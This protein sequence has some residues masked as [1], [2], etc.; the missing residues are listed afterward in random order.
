[1]NRPIDLPKAVRAMNCWEFSDCGRQPGGKN[2]TRR[3]ICPASTLQEANG[4]LGGKNGGR[5]CAFIIGSF[6]AA[7]IKGTKKDMTKNCLE[8]DFFLLLK[9][10]YGYKMSIASFV[11]HVRGG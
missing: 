5:A 8:C 2:A 1:M 4:F 7:T 11:K 6:C 10:Y 9:G 3:G